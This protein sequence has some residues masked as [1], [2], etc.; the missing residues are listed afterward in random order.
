MEH[1][2]KPTYRGGE[3]LPPRDILFTDR[4]IFFTGEV[5]S[6]SCDNLIKNLMALD[7]ESDKESDK[8]T[9]TI[10]LNSN[11]G[12]VMS[13]L[14]A[15]DVI[16]TLRSP[17]RTVVLGAAYSM[18][19]ILFL[20][21]QKR[22]IYEHGRIMIHD[23]SYSSGD[24]TGKKPH[25]IQRQVDNL[26]ETRNILAKIISETTG[27]ELSEVLEETREDRYYNAE[28]ALKAHLATN[29]IKPERK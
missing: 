17:V 2:I 6:E 19:A 21:G 12:D 27:K 24:I 22:E 3:Y 7:A 20:A 14:A 8:E 13:G 5:N 16:Q 11:G 10:F 25:E 1:L 23:P 9:I 15:Y 26:M 4:K 28:E 18:G 29:I